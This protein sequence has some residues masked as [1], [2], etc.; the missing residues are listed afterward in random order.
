MCDTSKTIGTTT[1]GTDRI[2]SSSLDA[3]VA[4]LAQPIAIAA[5]AFR[6]DCRFICSRTANGSFDK[7]D[8]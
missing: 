2:L 5:C 7:T 6:V 8:T 4:R 3:V 1:P